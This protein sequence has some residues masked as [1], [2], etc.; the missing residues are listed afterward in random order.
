VA[1]TATRCSTSVAA[2][3]LWW[4]LAPSAT[5]LQARP[6]PCEP[7]RGEKVVARSPDAY[8]LQ[9]KG[10]LACL[11][12]NGRRY[13]LDE[14]GDDV[15]PGFDVDSPVLAGRFV[16]VSYVTGSSPGGDF[17]SGLL[18]V[19]LRRGRDA[20]VAG[21]GNQLSEITEVRAKVLR[22]NGSFAWIQDRDDQAEGARRTVRRCTVFTCRPGGRDQADA[23]V[24]A[25]GFDIVARS[26]GLHGR[27][28]CWT[29]AGA[30]RCER[31]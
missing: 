24:L 14:V 18:L 23:P 30:R 31:V 8:V 2:A 3:A 27:R 16:L 13:R 12:P 25:E 11:R 7:V 5:A 4:S 15:D 17:G 1:S 6:G 19:D 20:A 21:F 9:G 10:T 22:R 29:Q 26:F 28:A